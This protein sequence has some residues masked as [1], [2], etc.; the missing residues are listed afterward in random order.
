MRFAHQPLYSPNTFFAVA[1]A[2]AFLVA[3]PE[4][5]ALSKAEWWIRFFFAV[6]S[7][8]HRQRIVVYPIP[9]RPIPLHS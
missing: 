4:E 2:V 7:H 1:V 8:R 6:D 3:I 5:P 9:N